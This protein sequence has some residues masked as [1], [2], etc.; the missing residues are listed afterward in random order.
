MPS[1]VGR[2]ESM[3]VLGLVS[4]PRKGGNSEL[5]A[6]EIMRQ[7]P[8]SWEKKM[9]RINELNIEYCRACYTCIPEDRKCKINDDLNF[10]IDNVKDADKIVISAPAYLLGEHTAMKLVVDRLLSI[11]TNFREFEGKECVIAASYGL[12]GWDG[13]VKEDLIIFAREFNLTITDFALLLATIPGDSVTGENLEKLHG[14]AK[15]LVKGI[16]SGKVPGD[17]LECPYCTSRALTLSIRGPWKCTVCGGKGVLEYTNGC[18]SLRYEAGDPFHFTAESKIMHASY[19]DE[20]KKL[21]LENRDSVREIQNRYSQMD[22][23]VRPVIS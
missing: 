12:H 4:S 11:L 14:L 5:A 13:L 23:W 9:I 10:L 8:E 15:S 18:Y 2:G 16:G 20:K 7:L 6:K 21:F 3:K 1:S 22:L 19:L 17:E